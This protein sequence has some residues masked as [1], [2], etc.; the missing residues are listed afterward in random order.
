M[1][2]KFLRWWNSD[3]FI[4]V[5]IEKAP[6]EVI[7]EILEWQVGDSIQTGYH[8]KFEFKGIVDNKIVISGD[9]WGYPNF[10][11]K[12]IWIEVTPKQFISKNYENITQSQREL[13]REGER[14]KQA[15]SQ[16]SYN[17]F[18]SMAKQS[19]DKLFEDYRNENKSN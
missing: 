16:D 14:L 1:W 5:Q 12:T 19:L 7:P 18:L 9:T 10:N 17:E 8:C 13:E 15:I 11:H 2:Q 3:L 6:H 4:E